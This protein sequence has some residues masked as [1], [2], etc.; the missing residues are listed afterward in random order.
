MIRGNIPCTWDQNFAANY[1]YTY[2][3]YTL[4]NHAKLADDNDLEK[5]HPGIWMVRD[6]GPTGFEFIY[7]NFHWLKDLHF[8]I[9]KMPPGSII[10][11]HTDR[12]PYY[13]EKYNIDDDAKIVRVI[14]FLQDWANGQY[15]EVADQG[16]SNWRAGDWIAW[17][18][19]TPHLAL[20]VGLTDRYVIQLTGTRY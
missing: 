1:D 4:T 11:L 17:D 10:P 14:I 13:S 5:Y 2:K 19:P 3:A 12:Y 18:L 8:Q 6:L 7:D 15:S 16:I 9:N 20:N